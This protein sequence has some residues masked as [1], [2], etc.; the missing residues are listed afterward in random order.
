MPF[1]QVTDSREFHMARE[2][3]VWMSL[4]LD[5]ELLAKTYAQKT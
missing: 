2:C 3:N 4:I 5:G 1:L